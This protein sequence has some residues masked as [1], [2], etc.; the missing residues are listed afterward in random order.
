[1]LFRSGSKIT[2]WRGGDTPVLVAETPDGKTVVTAANFTDRKARLAVPVG[3]K[4]LN[5]TVAP[6]SLNTYAE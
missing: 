2:A 1:M 5:I 3:K 4:Y 6:H